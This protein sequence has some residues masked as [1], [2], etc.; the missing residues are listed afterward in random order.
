MRVAVADDGRILWAGKLSIALSLISLAALAQPAVQPTSPPALP[1]AA[2]NSP[3]V[4]PLATRAQVAARNVAKVAPNNVPQRFSVA[5]KNRVETITRLDE[6]L[7]YGQVEPEDFV[8]AKT[9]PM[10]QF[11]ER[12]E[13]DRPMTP[14][15]KAQLAL[16]FIGLCGIYGPDGIPREPSLDERSEARINQSTT[17]LNSQFRGT[18][19]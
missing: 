18:L 7:V 2:I 16:C 10:V 8:G 13:R 5:D 4:D 14:K 11:R 6:I 1:A 12:L 15:Q 19:Q 17:Q 3:S 9:S